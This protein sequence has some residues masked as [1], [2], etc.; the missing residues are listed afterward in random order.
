[1]FH[2][3][4][5][6]EAADD[7]DSHIY[8]GKY[9]S[10]LLHVLISSPVTLLQQEPDELDNS[11]MLDVKRNGIRMVEL[12]SPFNLERSPRSELRTQILD[13]FHRS[14]HFV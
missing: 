6:A 10:G 14:L 3:T 11:F 12:I 2:F 9:Q 5:N 13:G 7:S 1:V 8:F 4:L